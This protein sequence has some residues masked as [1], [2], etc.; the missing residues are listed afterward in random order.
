[1]A[2]I[3]KKSLFILLLVLIL[4]I[5]ACNSSS[6]KEKHPSNY[7]TLSGYIGKSKENIFMD[8]DLNDGDEVALGLYLLNQK[9]DFYETSYNS[10]LVVEPSSE[11]VYQIVYN[12]SFKDNMDKAVKVLSEL[13]TQLV[14]IYGNTDDPIVNGFVEQIDWEKALSY[15]ATY[16]NWWDLTDEAGENIKEYISKKETENPGE[17]YSYILLVTVHSDGEKSVSIDLIYKISNDTK[18]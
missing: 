16:A 8:F 3:M 10:Q 15:D 4:S 6:V 7:E 2:K 1:M 14:K 9:A 12:Q 11:E 18:S 13:K 17:K 5:T